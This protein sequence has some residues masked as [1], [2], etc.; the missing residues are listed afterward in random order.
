MKWM[1]V[2]FVSG[3][4]FEV[5]VLLLKRCSILHLKIPQY[6]GIFPRGRSIYKYQTIY[7]FA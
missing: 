3:G 7:L 6:D 1:E 2:F 4:E 5:F